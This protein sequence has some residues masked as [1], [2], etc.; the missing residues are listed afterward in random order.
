MGRQN[1]KLNYYATMNVPKRLLI[2]LFWDEA[3][4]SAFPTIFQVLLMLLMW[5]PHIEIILLQDQLYCK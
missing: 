2:H 5:V 3:W 1:I 4:E